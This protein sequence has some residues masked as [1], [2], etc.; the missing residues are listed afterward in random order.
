MSS[1]ARP[2]DLP[3]FEYVRK[4]VREHSAIA[5][6]ANKTYLVETRLLPLAHRKGLSSVDDLVRQLKSQAFGELH[7]QTIEALTT[8]ETSFFRDIQP[9]EALRKDVLPP[10]IASRSASKTLHIWSAA[11]STGQEPYTIAILLAEH[12]PAL[13]DWQIRIIGSDLAQS[14][15][16]RAQAAEYS[17]FE[18]NRGLPAPLLVKYFEKRGLH[19]HVKPEIR[20]RVSFLRINLIEPWPSFPPLDI[21]FLRNVLIYF[22]LETKQQVLGQLRRRLAPD[23]ALFL[24]G[25]E[26]TLGIDGAWERICHGK[27]STYRPSPGRR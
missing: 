14:V 9:F 4:L 25:A 17:Q 19:W 5:L 13:H 18:V 21:V 23:G 10:L 2:L 22:E 7:S 15:L 6:E 3:A 1:T 24:G 8:N 26:T 20:R 12:F 27:S 16:D 11:C